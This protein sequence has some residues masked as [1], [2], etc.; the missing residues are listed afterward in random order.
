MNTLNL[1]P[2]IMGK[3]HYQMSWNSPIFQT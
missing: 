1:L 3:S 2:I